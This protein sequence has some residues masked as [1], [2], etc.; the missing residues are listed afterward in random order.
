MDKEN[1]AE[2]LRK[3][4]AMV[5]QKNKDGSVGSHLRYPPYNKPWDIMYDSEFM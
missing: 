4:Y 1:L 3:F 5:R 2:L